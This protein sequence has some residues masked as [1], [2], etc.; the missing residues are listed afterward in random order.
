MIQYTKT[1]VADK[2]AI[3]KN[4]YIILLLKTYFI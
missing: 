1:K 2:F 4:K 3:I